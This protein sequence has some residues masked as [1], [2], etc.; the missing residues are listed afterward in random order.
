MLIVQ[1]HLDN[2][3]QNLSALK[4]VRIFHEIK[5][6]DLKIYTQITIT[7]TKLNQIWTRITKINLSSCKTRWV[8]PAQLKVNK[9]IRHCTNRYM[10]FRTIRW[11][12]KPFHRVLSM[13][14]SLQ[15]NRT[16][17]LEVLT[18]T[19]YQYHQGKSQFICKFSLFQY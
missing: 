9:M 18:S 17:Q 15:Q 2:P 8:I 16:S 14:N 10:D 4:T 5:Q 19:S 1:T 12:A 3:H 7:S 13:K 6:R 11:R